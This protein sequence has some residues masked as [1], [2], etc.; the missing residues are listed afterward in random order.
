MEDIAKEDVKPNNQHNIESLLSLAKDVRDETL[1]CLNRETENILKKIKENCFGG[2]P[3]EN[4]L[5]RHE[6]SK[7]LIIKNYLKT[8]RILIV[9]EITKSSPFTTDLLKEEDGKKMPLDRE[10]QEY[11][12]PD[13]ARIEKIRSPG[14]SFSSYHVPSYSKILTGFC[15]DPIY[16][17]TLTSPR[18]KLGVGIMEKHMEDV[19]NR[20]ALSSL[21]EAVFDR[22]FG[23]PSIGEVPEIEDDEVPE[24]EDEEVPKLKEITGGDLIS[25]RDPSE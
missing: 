10:T 16:N 1:S 6:S 25:M 17:E 24:L 13:R 23:E 5:S 15:P 2:N 21:M 11:G 9:S 18:S 4:Q 19:K 12:R 8:T 7:A 3:A 20:E 14:H 22:E